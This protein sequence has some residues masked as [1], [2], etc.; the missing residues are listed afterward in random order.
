MCGGTSDL[1]GG[2]T[3]SPMQ[4]STESLVSEVMKVIDHQGYIKEDAPQPPLSSQN[5][6]RLVRELKQGHL[7]KYVTHEELA[8]FD[9]L[10]RLEVAGLMASNVDLP[11]QLGLRL[12]ALEKEV[13]QPGGAFARM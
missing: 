6:D 11:D 5:I 1:F 12:S 2:L 10:P 13:I 7:S 8:R 9:Y 4:A 3:P